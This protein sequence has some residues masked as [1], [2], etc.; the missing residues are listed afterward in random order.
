MLARLSVDYFRS[1]LNIPGWKTPENWDC[2]LSTIRNTLFSN[3]NCELS[4]N[5]D[6]DFLL[7]YLD[8]DAQKVKKQVANMLKKWKEIGLNKVSW[9]GNRG[10]L[11]EIKDQFN[12]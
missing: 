9:W 6:G 1:V 5:D 2:V 10:V 11:I 3:Q 4:I 12:F 7:T 8:G